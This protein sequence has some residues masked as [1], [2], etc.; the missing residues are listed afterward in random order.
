MYLCLAPS[1][2]PSFFLSSFYIK[3]NLLFFLLLF[4]G[5]CSVFLCCAQVL[6]SCSEW[7]YSFLWCR[8]FSLWRLLL[9]W[10]I[11]LGTQASV[12]VAHGLQ[13]WAQWL[14]YMDFSWST[15]CRIFLDR[16][17][18]PCLLHQQ[19]G[20]YPLYHQGSPILLYLICVYNILGTVLYGLPGWYSG[21]ESACHPG[22]DGQ[23]LGWGRSPGKGS[24]NPLQYS[25]GKSQGQ[26]SL[27]GYSPWG[28]RRV[29]L[30]LV[31]KQ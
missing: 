25:F 3:K 13:S 18:N 21:K 6:S 28:H 15:A 17:S 20:S 26:R 29:I 16:P 30:D 9:L 10:N 23:I 12:V 27:A 2:F 22:D 14:W 5:L 24:G 4:W 1:S 8:G 7:G 19:M 31:T 11:V